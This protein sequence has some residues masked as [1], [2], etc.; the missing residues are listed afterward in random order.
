MGDASYDCSGII[1]WVFRSFDCDITK[2]PVGI[3]LEITASAYGSLTELYSPTSTM[4]FVSTGIQ[5]G[6][7]ERLNELQRGDLVLL[8]NDSRSRIGHIMVYLGNNTVIHSTRI[9]GRYRG[10]LV[11]KFR[12]H[13]QYLYA[14]SKRIGEIKP[15]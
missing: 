9:T 14:T 12:D 13:L 1:C 8:L 4:T 5:K 15:R 6:E 3:P 2:K 11:A 7:R 10:T